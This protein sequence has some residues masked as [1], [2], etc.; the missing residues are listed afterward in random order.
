M[1]QA[2][3]VRMSRRWFTLP[4]LGVLL[5]TPALSFLNVEAAGSFASPAFQKQWAAGE[6]I[7]PNF[8]GPLPLAH[9]GQN[10]PYVEAPGG[11]RLVQY[12]DKARMELTNPSTG[13]VTNGLLATELITGKLQAGDS[14]FR[15][16]QPAAIPVAGDSNNAGPTYAQIG[17][18]GLTTAVASAVG[19]PTTRA[20]SSAG[21]AGTFAAGGSDANATIATFDTTT[22]HNV[23]KAFNDYRNKAGL[24]TIGL[25]IAEPF[26]ANGVLV[27]GQPK[28]VL[29]QA[30]E[31][32]V[33]T[34]T[35]SNPD[36]FKVEFGNIGSHYFTWRYVTN[37]GGGTGTTTGGTGTT[38]GGGTTNPACLAFQNQ[39]AA[40]RTQYINIAPLGGVTMRPVF[41]NQLVNLRAMFLANGCQGD[42]DISL[43]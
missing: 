8:W 42:F 10:E 28:D 14:T 13:T 9:D 18:S 37:A 41:E 27:G 15:Q 21:A 32:R 43:P 7:T 22:Q 31:R 11:S 34:Y 24:L 16:L 25:A 35:P 2:A 26:W 36:A 6:A 39:G 33:L 20:L 40:L 23:P 12:F 3:R 38:T 5:L 1:G 17:T 19:Q 4:V 30:F 29:V